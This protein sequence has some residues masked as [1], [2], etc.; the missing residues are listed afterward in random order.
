MGAFKKVGDSVHWSF[1]NSVV[2]F[3][4]IS[5]HSL[6]SLSPSFPC[7]DTHTHTLSL[8]NF[9]NPFIYSIFSL[10]YV[11]DSAHFFW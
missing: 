7:S 6:T 9:H 3:E 5:L 1:L 11:E 8:L 10:V 2:I 4:L